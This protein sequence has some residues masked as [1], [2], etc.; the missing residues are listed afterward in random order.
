MPIGGFDFILISEKVK[1]NIIKNLEADFFL[2]GKI[3]WIGY[4]IKYIPYKRSKR[5]T[6]KSQWTFSMKLKWFI[7]SLMSYSLFPIRAMTSIGIILSVSGFMYAIYVFIDGLLSDDYVP[8]NAVVVVLILILSGFQILMLGVI[9][10]YIWRTLSQV[11][12]R[13]QYIIEE[14]IG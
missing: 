11:R 12:N 4:D 10:E 5:K 3:L 7:D 1:N 14:I 2:Q 8:G 13:S 6:G 9:G